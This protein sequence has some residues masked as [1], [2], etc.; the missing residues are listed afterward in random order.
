MLQG[1]STQY[2]FGTSV[3]V[4]LRENMAQAKVLALL[5]PSFLDT[6]FLLTGGSFLLTME[7]FCLQLTI[8]AFLLTVGA[9]LLAALAFS[10]GTVSK[11]A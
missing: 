4:M 1:A 2:R 6:A 10:W 11:E 5:T 3:R 9:F 7:L 8:L